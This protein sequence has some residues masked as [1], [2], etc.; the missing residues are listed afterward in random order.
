MSRSS[1]SPALREDGLGWEERPLKTVG[2]TQPRSP[3]EVLRWNSAML[4]LSPFCGQWCP[5][6][7]YKFKTWEEEHE[8]TQAQL[9]AADS[10]RK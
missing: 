6:G 9:Q 8:W 5:P 10:R 2:R 3:A 1:S 4:K 7:V